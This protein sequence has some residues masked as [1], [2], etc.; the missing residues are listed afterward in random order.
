[1]DTSSCFN[2]FFFLSLWTLLIKQLNEWSFS[3]QKGREAFPEVPASVVGSE[4]LQGGMALEQSLMSA[5]DL[6]GGDV[7]RTFLEEG[8]GQKRGGEAGGTCGLMREKGL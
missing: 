1:M 8:L 2:F 5:R 4:G 6:P 3:G 7:E